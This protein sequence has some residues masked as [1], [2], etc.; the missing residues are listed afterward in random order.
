MVQKITHEI[1]IDI[2]QS[3]NKTFRYFYKKV[4]DKQKPIITAIL[5]NPAKAD[6]IISDKTL[7]T[8]ANEFYDRSYGGMCILNLFSYM[9][10]N[11]DDLINSNRGK[12]IKNYKYVIKYIK[13][14]T[15]MD[16]FIG[17]GNS[18]DKL[19][20]NEVNIRNMA[21]RKKKRIEE[22][23]NRISNRVYCYESN[24]G[25]GLHPSRYKLTW[26]YRNYF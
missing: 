18:L 19:P 23:L 20:N 24:Y 16:Y 22:L 26:Q 10:Q 7:D 13:K 8:L 9:C 21:I 1:E 15:N 25:K 17:W 12:E 4:W 2:E 5:L 3:N 14:N 11:P 6:L